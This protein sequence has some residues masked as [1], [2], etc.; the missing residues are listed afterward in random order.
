[1]NK[2]LD[3]ETY[4]EA[5]EKNI[6]KTY[7]SLDDITN[8]CSVIKEFFMREVS[9]E[10][11][12]QHILDSDLDGTILLKELQE[13][14]EYQKII[15]RLNYEQKSQL[16]NSI[17]G[18]LTELSEIKQEKRGE[19]TSESVKTISNTI[20][21]FF[22]KIKVLLFG[23]KEKDRQ[24]FTRE[25]EVGYGESDDREKIKNEWNKESDKYIE[26]FEDFIGKISRNNIAV[27]IV[28]AQ[29]DHN[30][31]KN[32]IDNSKPKMNDL[33]QLSAPYTPSLPSSTFVKVK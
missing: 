5:E 10:R 17:L 4:L 33:E 32:N 7:F 6:E 9:H 1:M 20:K 24:M 25:M 27:E 21:K 16:E 26:I 12:L 15:D 13:R 3:A 8:F 11:D 23:N 14:P 29:K 28:K 18:T 19:F 31:E 22:N 30:M 2:P